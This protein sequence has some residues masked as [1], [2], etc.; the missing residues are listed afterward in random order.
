[1][2]TPIN[3]SGQIQTRQVGGIEPVLVEPD[4]VSRR[5]ARKHLLGQETGVHKSLYQHLTR[6]VSNFLSQIMGRDQDEKPRALP[7][8]NKQ[9]LTGSLPANSNEPLVVRGIADRMPRLVN[10]D[11]PFPSRDLIL[12]GE[13]RDF[14]EP[15]LAV[16][17]G[18]VI[19]PVFY[20]GNQ[21]VAR[22]LYLDCTQPSL[23]GQLVLADGTRMPVIIKIITAV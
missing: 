1:M 23:D 9:R 14:P 16:Q 15:V 8:Q 2:L 3:N 13:A 6:L 17:Y 22:N 4:Q 5:L 11:D 10:P 19:K 20:E 21:V 18:D 12:L 7:N